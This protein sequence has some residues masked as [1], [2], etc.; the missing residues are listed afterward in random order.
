MKKYLLVFSILA[1]ACVLIAYF[2]KHRAARESEG[3]P[4]VLS[5]GEIEAL[6]AKSANGDCESSTRLAMYYLYGALDLDAATKWL[7]LAAKC[8]DVT[9]KEYLAEILVRNKD[10]PAAATEVSQ[11]VAEIRAIDPERAAKLEDRLKEIAGSATSQQ[12]K[13]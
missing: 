11:L 5:A 10:D 2:A 6:K 4:Y 13:P 1:V 9:P 3:F 7:R 12:G 8:P